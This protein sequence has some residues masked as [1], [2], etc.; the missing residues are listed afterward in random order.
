MLFD[1]SVSACWSW[2]AMFDCCLLFVVVCDCSCLLFAGCCLM[3]VV[4]CLLFAG[5]CLL[6]AV[7]HVFFAVRCL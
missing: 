1:G 2:S 3:A 6:F 7:S 5:F 4:G